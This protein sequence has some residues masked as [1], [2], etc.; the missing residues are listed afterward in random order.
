MTSDGAG[1]SEGESAESSK[2]GRPAKDFS[3]LSKRSRDRSTAPLR[4]ENS[5]EKLLHAAAI[6]LRDEGQGDFASVIAECQES[7]TRPSKFRRLSGVA[8]ALDSIPKNNVT[9]PTK[10]SPKAALAFVLGQNLTK[11]NYIALRVISKQS[12][13]GIWLAYQHVLK[14]RDAVDEPLEVSESAQMAN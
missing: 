3:D 4:E 2:G 7:P 13:A 8:D 5:G 11:E 6:K 1:S 10:I 9:L 14:A 12:N